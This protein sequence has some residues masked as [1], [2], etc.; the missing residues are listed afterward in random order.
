MF[1]NLS[2]IQFFKLILLPKITKTLHTFAVEEQVIW[3]YKAHASSGQTQKVPAQIVKLGMKRIKIRV[4]Q[5][6]GEFVERWVNPSK[7]EKVNSL[8]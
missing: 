1:L 8:L 2:S 5:N 7:L 6:N 4:K 3:S